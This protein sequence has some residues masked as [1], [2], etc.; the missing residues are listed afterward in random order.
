M[1]FDPAIIPVCAVAVFSAL[2]YGMF[3]FGYALLAVATLP[4][5][6]SVKVAVP[7]I[8]LQVPIYNAILIY[9]LRRH[10]SMRITLPIVIGL[11]LG[12]PIGAHLLRILSEETIRKLLGAVILLHSLGSIRKNP[13]G[14]PLL[15]SDRWGLPAGF[16]SGVIG[17][18]IIAA[19]P[20]VV[21][22]LTLRGFDKERTKATFLVW[23]TAQTV[24]L[25]PFY[26]V[27]GLLTGQVLRWG[28]ITMPFVGLGIFF[29]VKIF[30]RLEQR[31][32]YRLIVILL[33]I[34][35]LR[36]LFS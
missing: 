8:A 5:F 32:F 36:L 29:G 7:M 18:A 3:G 30:D 17:G 12:L 24:L 27:S 34:M 23:A 16:L 2:I 1:T 14:A 15:H 4:F 13:S 6:I 33:T 11:V 9:G 21:A 35:G 10:L 25:I 22:Y 19:G 31:L 20:I 28:L 26:A